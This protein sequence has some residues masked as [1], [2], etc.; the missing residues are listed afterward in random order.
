MLPRPDVRHRFPAAFAV[1]LALASARSWAAT[2]P[3]KVAG[4]FSTDYEHLTIEV[5]PLSKNVYFLHGSGGNTAALL[6]PEGTLL[7]DTEL[8]AVAAK[9]KAALDT[10]KAG[11][12]RYVITTHY[13]SDHAGGNSLFRKGGAVLIAQ[14]QC[15]ARLIQSQ[16]ILYGGWVSPAIPEEE[17]PTMTFS[18]ILTLYFN[19]EEVTAMHLQPSHSDGDAVV[20]FKHANVVHLGD[21]YINGLYPIIDIGAKGT[22]EGYFPVID[23]VL[24]RIDDRTIVIPGH[25]PV[26]NKRE[27][28][29]YRDMLWTVRNR[30]SALVAQG[31]SL[32]EVI[33]ARPSQE[34][35]EAW[36]SDR[37][38]P[39]GFAAMVY[40]SLTGRRLQWRPAH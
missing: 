12:T 26:S 33:A 2:P 11:P 14:E 6:G 16:V 5:K 21:I 38:G 29:F 25:G 20:Y 22:I 10:L 7:V 3:W 17:A 36:A 8:A 31:K 30:V 1:L 40:Q 27:L 4:G 19:G 15:R 35:D 13:H 18:R 39:D 32:E 37:V 24:S 9:L 23:E 28:Q 34:F